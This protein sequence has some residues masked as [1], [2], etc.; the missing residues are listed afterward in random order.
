MIVRVQSLKGECK[1]CGARADFR[2]TRTNEDL[3]D[4]YMKEGHRAEYYC[5]VHMPHEARDFWN[6]N[7]SDIPGQQL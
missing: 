3:P 4:G 5:T 6:F 7:V 2:I 1:V